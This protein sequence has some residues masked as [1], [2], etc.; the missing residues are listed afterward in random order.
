MNIKYVRNLRKFK[1]RF[2][3]GKNYFSAWES[4]LDNGVTFLFFLSIILLPFNGLTKLPYIF[5]EFSVEGSFYP[6]LLAFFLM[7]IRVLVYQTIELPNNIGAKLLITFLIIIAISGIFNISDITS[8]SF[9]GRTGWNKLLLQAL[10][11]FFGFCV[12]F[13]V[14]DVAKRNWGENAITYIKNASL[15]SFAIVGAYS[16]IELNY[17]FGNIWAQDCL[18]KINAIFRSAGS[19]LYLGRVRSVCRE[20]SFFGIYFSFIYPFLLMFL[21]KAKKTFFLRLTVIVYAL[22]LCF[23]TFSRTVYAIVIT[24]TSIILFLLFIKSISWKDKKRVLYFLMALLI[25]GTV[26]VKVNNK[27][28]DVIT[29]FNTNKPLNQYKGSNVGRFGSTVAAIKMGLDNPVFGIGLGQYGFF[30]PEYIPRWAL[31][32]REV[33][34]WADPN[35]GKQWPVVHNIHA[36]IFAEMGSVGIGIWIAMWI[37]LFVSLFKIYIRKRKTDSSNNEVFLI[38]AIFG[39][40]LSGMNVDT[41]RNMGYWFVII[42]SWLTIEAEKNNSEI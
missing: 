5:G 13:M 37:Y 35:R 15:I 32:S 19:L 11:V 34:R 42:I 30:M 18:E 20:A 26:L 6:L 17:L 23:F 33:R 40:I 36:R 8:S 39:V 38:A 29:S 7:S 22:V 28:T 14:Y 3:E 9:S 4:Y 41:F 12:C 10:V 31:D 25:T 1:L 16:F 24:E 21:F 27:S 2:K